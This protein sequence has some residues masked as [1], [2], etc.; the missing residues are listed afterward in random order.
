MSLRIGVDLLLLVEE[1]RKQRREK[2]VVKKR[3]G[4]F[5]GL[6]VAVEVEVDRVGL[7]SGDMLMMGGSGGGGRWRRLMVHL[8]YVGRRRNER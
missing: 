8:V 3:S 6:V 2:A 4:R 7:G 5:L 1:V